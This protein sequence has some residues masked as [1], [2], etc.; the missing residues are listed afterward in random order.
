MYFSHVKHL[1]TAGI[2]EKN[3]PREDPSKRK[4][5]CS[6]YPVKKLSKISSCLNRATEAEYEYLFSTRWQL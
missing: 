4:G 2:N 3:I 5:E 1:D 6:K